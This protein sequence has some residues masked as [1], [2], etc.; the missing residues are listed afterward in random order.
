MQL[1]GKAF[2]KNNGQLLRSKN[3]AK[4]FF[5]NAQRTTVIGDN[6]VHGYTEMPTEPK[7][8]CVIS[9]GA[10]INMEELKNIKDASITFE[11]DSGKTFILRNAWLQNPLELT[12]NENAELPCVFAGMSC[13]EL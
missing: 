12:A 2:I 4:L 1:T 10:D 8:E 9:H 7:V 3:G 5:G 6:G 13:E 11:T